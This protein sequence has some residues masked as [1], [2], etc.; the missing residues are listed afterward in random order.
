MS[1]VLLNEREWYCP[2]CDVRLHTTAHANG[3]VT[4][5]DHHGNTRTAPG[6]ASTLQHRCRGMNLLVVPMLPVGTAAKHEAVEREDY[7]GGED[8][9]RD[10]E[11]RPV[12]ATITTTDES[13]SATVYAP[14]A[15]QEV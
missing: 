6:D 14:C 13:Q 11:G 7:E 2:D 3:T 8:V 12:M 5:L 4:V 9:Q 15:H 10:A 1:A